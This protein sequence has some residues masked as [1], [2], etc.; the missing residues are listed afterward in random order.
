MNNKLFKISNQKLL[1]LIALI[2]PAILLITQVKIS[3]TSAIFKNDSSAQSDTP[4]DEAYTRS[5]DMLSPA[6]KLSMVSL[7][8]NISGI[9]S[10]TWTVVGSATGVSVGY[11]KAKDLSYIIT[12]NHFCEDAISN[13]LKTV[14]VEDSS[15]PR[16]NNP[17][18]DSL[19]A[20]VLKVDPEKDLCLLGTKG[21]IKPAT[22]AGYNVDVNKFDKIY[23]VGGPTGIFPT[24]LDTYV[25]GDMDRGKVSLPGIS[26]NGHK[27][28]FIS[29]I[30][31]PGHSGSPVYNE[32]HEVIG[33]VFATVPSY[34]AL[35]IPIKDVY[36]FVE[37]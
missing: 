18:S 28:L 21:Y 26:R 15:S 8:S 34:G 29:G 27:F 12:N 23:I 19:M 30:I 25:S 24:I 20:S 4:N 3:K 32:N 10:S 1:V 17:M 13:S 9:P 31:L 11:D 22:M 7:D 35:A 37:Q 16:V 2:I 36:D 14:I 5:R 33:I 6:V